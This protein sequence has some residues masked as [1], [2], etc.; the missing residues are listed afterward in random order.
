MTW[1]SVLLDNS[2]ADS[3]ICIMHDP[4]PQTLDFL[5]LVKSF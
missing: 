5:P 4:Y 3:C 1:H 2:K